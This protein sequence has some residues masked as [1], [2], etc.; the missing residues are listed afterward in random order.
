MLKVS[1]SR[2]IDDLVRSLRRVAENARSLNGRQTIPAGELFN[3]SF[4]RG[5]TRYQSL[6]EFQ[7]HSP[8]S[9]STSADWVPPAEFE[10]LVREQ[11]N[12]SSWQ[13]M[14]KQAVDQ[15]AKARLSSGVR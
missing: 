3:P 14:L 12:F 1:G 6:D 7:R 8:C 9:L 2:G 10:Q 15:W 13:A 4:M 11:T 5:H